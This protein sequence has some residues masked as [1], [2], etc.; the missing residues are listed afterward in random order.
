MWEFL[1]WVRDVEKEVKPDKV[2]QFVHTYMLKTKLASVDGENV[3]FSTMAIRK[4]L[5]LPDIGMKLEALPE[6]KKVEAEEIF[7]YKIRWGKDVKLN[8]EVT[9]HHWP[10][11]FE[12][13]N[14]YLLFKP[15]DHK[16][17]QK[18]LV[19]AVRTWE[20]KEL[21]WARIVQYRIN[22]EIQTRKAQS[23]DVIR[24]Y[25][26]FYITCLCEGKPEETTPPRLTSPG[27]PTSPDSPTMVELEFELG[28]ARLALR[29]VE[30]KLSEKKDKL[31]EVQEKS[32]GYLQQI[33]QLL[34]DKFNDHKR[35]DEL[36]AQN[37]ELKRQLEE[38]QQRPVPERQIEKGKEPLQPLIMERSSNTE[39]QRRGPSTSMVPVEMEQPVPILTKLP[40]D[41][42]SKL[43]DV[44][45]KVM[46]NFNLHHLYVVQRDLFLTMVGLGVGACLTSEQFQELWDFATKCL[47]ENLFTEI[48]ARKHLILLDPFQAYIVIGDVGAR[49]Y[50]YYADCEDQLYN[51]RTLGRQV[52]E[53]VVDWTDYGTQMAQQLYG[54]DKETRAKWRKNLEGLLPIMK[55]EDF[56]A[57]VV[58]CNLMRTYRM[59]EN[60]DFTGSHYIYNR[61]RSLER[62]ERYIQAVEARKAPIFAMQSQVQF[63]VAP[64]GYISTFTKTIVIPEG[65]SVADQRYLGRY[66]EL[67]D[68]APEQPIPTWPAL[69]WILQDYGLSRVE[70]MAAD[71]VYKQI[72]G[73]WSFEPPPAVHLHPQFC[74]CARRH[75]WAPDATIASVEYN[76]PQIQG[77]PGF[78]TPAQCRD[79][80]QRFFDEHKR[81]KDPVCFRAAIFCAVLADWCPRWNFA[82]NVNMHHK[83]QQEFLMMLKLQYRPSRWLRVVE[84]MSMTHFI[85]GAHTS[86]INEFPFTR[87]GPF[88]RFLKWQRKN[89]PQGV[90]Q[91]EDLQRAIMRLEAKEARQRLQGTGSQDYM[92]VDEDDDTE[93]SVKRLRVGRD[94]NR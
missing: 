62:I 2:A 46:P 9:R 49:I 12:F 26:A 73:P 38:L 72:C 24:L 29:E 8:F 35:F 69:N 63:L 32:A 17:E 94:A 1:L 14:T 11:W 66:E 18:Y 54:Q 90:A 65:G 52:E 15:E 79:A 39:D 77:A 83:S 28:K 43:W 22:E 91:D 87:C 3:D 55:H 34:Q 67:F 92:E 19:A 78:N 70:E 53:R 75:K 21:D 48:L 58:S 57:R 5:N 7:D 16:M 45:R 36:H 68:H 13:V 42:C 41:I 89:N 59:I 93:G 80:Y 88:E 82:I 61:D 51:R 85:E 10:E 81:H 44:E 25:S 50:L 40:L 4:V 56:L 74:P 84:V 23:P 20:G 71:L 27:R 47:S 64:P 30:T 37:V 60:E 76:W 31:V 86:M 33:N 6:M